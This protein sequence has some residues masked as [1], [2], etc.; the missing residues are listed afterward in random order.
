[1]TDQLL[2]CPYCVLGNEFGP[3]THRSEGWFICLKCGHTVRHEDPGFKCFCKKCSELYRAAQNCLHSFRQ[4]IQGFWD[5][6]K[7]E[8]DLVDCNLSS[9]R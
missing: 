4:H 9:L 2:R 1:M 3:M 8:G 5:A 7:S 6:R